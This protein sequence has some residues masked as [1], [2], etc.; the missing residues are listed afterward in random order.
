M[1]LSGNGL[2]DLSDLYDFKHLRSLY[3][4]QNKLQDVPQLLSLLNNLDSLENL[5]LTG[6]PVAKTTRYREMVTMANKNLRVLDGKEISETSRQFLLRM[7]DSRSRTSMPSMQRMSKNSALSHQTM[8][9]ST[10]TAVTTADFPPQRHPKHILPPSVRPI[11]SAMLG[12]VVHRDSKQREQVARVTSLAQAAATVPP[13]EREMVYDDADGTS[14]AD[15]EMNDWRRSKDDLSVPDR[16][17]EELAH[18]HSLE[19][20]YFPP[21]NEKSFG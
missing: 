3:A 13:Y 12:Q 5:D 6:N 21:L 18:K 14:T 15:R 8:P 1:D 10:H 7:K 17:N 16:L 19:G 20:N 2:T 9:T 11:P 4:K